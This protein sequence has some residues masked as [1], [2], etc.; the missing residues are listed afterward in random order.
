LFYEYNRAICQIHLDND[1]IL[2]QKSTD[3]A[4]K[5]ILADLQAANSSN[6]KSDIIAYDPIIKEWLSLNGMK[7]V[8]PL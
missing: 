5:R 3:E 8:P 2:K 4:K 7:K 1:F 6:L